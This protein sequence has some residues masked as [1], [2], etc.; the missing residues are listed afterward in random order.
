MVV[1][2]IT[3][4]FMTMAFKLLY[5]SGDIE[6]IMNIKILARGGFND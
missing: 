3:N 6:T 4:Y 5:Y 1:K 2:R